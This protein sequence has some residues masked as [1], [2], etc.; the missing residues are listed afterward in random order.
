MAAAMKQFMTESL[1]LA[2]VGGML[3]LAL[4]YGGDRLLTYAMSLSG[5][6][7]PNA[8]VIDV[9]WRVLLFSLGITII[10]GVAFGLAPSWVTSRPTLTYLSKKGDGARRRENGRARLRNGLV[11]AEMVLALVLLTGAGLLIRTFVHLVNVDLGIDPANVVT[12]GIRLPDYKYPT[13]EQQKLFYRELLR[14]LSGTTG[15]KG[16]SGRGRVE[17]ILPTA[18]AAGRSSGTRANSVLQHCDA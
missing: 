7:L 3:G 1:L 2:A 8:R 11:V 17:C 6:R 18:G 5:I 14:N 10:T 13:T 12:M 9:D 4:A 15:V 16:G